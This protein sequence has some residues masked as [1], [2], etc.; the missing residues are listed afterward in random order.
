MPSKDPKI[1]PQQE[2]RVFTPPAEEQIDPMADAPPA[3]PYEEAITPEH[4]E[5]LSTQGV[6]V[7]E[8]DE[9]TTD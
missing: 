2:T 1:E 8:P 6:V 5:F 9:G 4:R 7:A 3:R